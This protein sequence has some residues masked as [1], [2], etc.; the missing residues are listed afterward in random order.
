MV[1]TLQIKLPILHPAQQKIVDSP[2]KFK[3]VCCGRRFGKT[4]L[5]IDDVTNHLL[6]GK[7]YGYFA[8]NYDDLHKLAWKPLLN[9]LGPIIKHKDQTKRTIE[10]VTGGLFIGFSMEVDRP[11]QGHQFHKVALD[12]A[13]TVAQLK[14]KFEES[15]EPTLVDFDGDVVWY[16]T[17]R[18]HN[19]FWQLY[20]LGQDPLQPDWQSFHFTSFSNPHISHTRLDSIKARVPLRTWEQEYLAEFTSDGGQVFRRVDRVATLP[21]FDPYPGEFIFGVDWGRVNDFTAVSIIDVNTRQQVLIDRINKIGYTAQRNW[22]MTLYEAWKPFRIIAEEN[23]I[24]DANIDAI[25]NQ[26]WSEAD[27]SRQKALG[28]RADGREFPERYNQN[29]AQE[30]ALIRKADIYDDFRID[31]FQTTTISKPIIIDE[32]T[33]AIERGQITLQDDTIQLNEMKSY[34]LKRLPSGRF[35]FGAPSGGNDDTVIATALSW[36]GLTESGHAGVWD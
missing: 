33:T 20:Q 29:L 36:H 6:D 24:G 27:I 9:V 11:G 16:S 31:G 18:G 14:D 35:Q 15:I 21:R 26:A 12:E 22:L 3:V 13:A 19:D 4:L 17:P 30:I 1:K 25:R 28:L 7:A 2:A 34:A 10:T 8:P 32:L 5:S 23:S